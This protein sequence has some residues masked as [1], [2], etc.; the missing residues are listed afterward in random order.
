MLGS[1]RIFRAGQPHRLKS[2]RADPEPSDGLGDDQ[3]HLESSRQPLPKKRFFQETGHP[4]D[5]LQ[6]MEDAQHLKHAPVR[7]ARDILIQTIRERFS[8]AHGYTPSLDILTDAQLQAILEHDQYGQALQTDLGFCDIM[9]PD[10]QDPISLPDGTFAQKNRL[11]ASENS[12]KK[13]SEKVSDFSPYQA[14]ASLGFVGKE[15]KG[16]RAAYALYLK[17]LYLKAFYL[18]ASRGGIP[19]VFSLQNQED[20]RQHTAYKGEYPHDIVTRHQSGQGK[21]LLDTKGLRVK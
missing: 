12:L 18:K 10:D 17:A 8:C 14:V 5:P 20:I 16:W 21:I 6:G 19:V 11:H 7:G 9:I 15:D 1:G 3:E 4:A 13:A 2:Q